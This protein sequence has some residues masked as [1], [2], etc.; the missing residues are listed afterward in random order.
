MY[1]LLVVLRLWHIKEPW[2]DSEASSEGVKTRVPLASTIFVSK[3]T[4]V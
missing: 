2:D 4:N 3:S 1:P